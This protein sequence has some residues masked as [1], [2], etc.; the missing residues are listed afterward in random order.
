MCVKVH[1]TVQATASLA[2]SRIT[3]MPVT[4]GFE[5]QPQVELPAQG[6]LF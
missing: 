2:N 1:C 5:W 3:T 4:K 6:E